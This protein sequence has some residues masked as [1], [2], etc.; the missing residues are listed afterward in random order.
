VLA[1][2]VLVAEVLASGGVLVAEILASGGGLVTLYYGVDL[3]T[4]QGHR[5]G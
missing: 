5:E 2:L 1:H 4:K 3:E